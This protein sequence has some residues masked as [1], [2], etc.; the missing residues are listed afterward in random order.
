[1]FKFFLSFGEKAAKAKF[2]SPQEFL[3][4]ETPL[5]G[6][7]IPRNKPENEDPP[8][9]YDRALTNSLLTFLHERGSYITPSDNEKRQNALSKLNE[10]VNIFVREVY[11]SKTNEVSNIENVCGKLVTYGSFRLGISNADSDIDALCIAPKYVT[12]Q[13]FFDTFY[14]KLLNLTYVSN[15]V[16]IEQAKVPLLTMKFQGIDID[17]AFVQIGAS[18][19]DSTMDENYLENDT[20]IDDGSLDQR[21]ITSLNGPRVS[22]MIQKLVRH[23]ENF[24]TLL[25]FTR[26]WA[27][28]RGLY[29]NVYG[30]L[31]GVNLALLC[32]FICQR[33]PTALPSKL[34]AMFFQDMSTWPWPEP[35]YINTPNTGT[36]PSWDNSIGSLGRKDLMPVITPAYPAMNSLQYATRSSKQRMIREFTRGYLKTKDVLFNGEYWDVVVTPSNFFMMYRTYVQ[37][38]AWATTNDDFNKWIGKVESRIR[39]LTTY[40][41][42]ESNFIKGV[43]IWPDHFDHPDDEGHPFAGSFFI[44][45]EYEIPKEENVERRIDIS[46]ACQ[47]FIDN[48]YR[49]KEPTENIGLNMKKLTRSMLPDYVFP[50]GQRP[51]PK[52]KTLITFN[53]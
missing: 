13:D 3:M 22:N 28:E 8:A 27:K 17:L 9:D 39:T 31:G 24:Q 50:N 41:E 23:V 42:T 49:V 20:I 53:S 33:Y 11:Q 29:G 48:V 32:A 4:T 36:Q 7:Y 6:P 14:K 19:I 1:M 34:I 47:R 37:V 25:R 21:S 51:E 12:R 5:S 18:E 40:L 30:Y 44:A 16:K 2:F 38:I 52:H 15:L 43:Y 45:L 46:N 10:L 26:I 35:I